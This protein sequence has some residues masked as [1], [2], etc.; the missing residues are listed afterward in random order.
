MAI[1]RK[2]S[3][4]DSITN[5]KIHILE[6]GHAFL[7]TEW[8]LNLT[9]SLFNRLYFVI[10]GEGYVSNAYN[11]ITLEK[12]YVYFLPINN[13]YKLRCD[14]KLEKVYTHF[15]VQI[16]PGIDLFDGIKECSRIKIEKNELDRLVYLLNSDS[17]SDILEYKS[18][19][20]HYVS[21]FLAPYNDKLKEHIKLFSPYASILSYI[22]KNCHAGLKISEIAQHFDI[23]YFSLIKNFKRDMNL[24]LKKYIDENIIRLSQQ[25]LL[26]TDMSIKEIAYSLKFSD[27]FNFSHFFKKHAGM[28]P[29]D[30]RKKNRTTF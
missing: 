4:L 18:I 8:H 12:E 25:K 14:N 20:S 2:N 24:S 16:L 21:R 27:E 9:Y 23:S 10:S 1:L 3:N 30:F 13:P 15:Q 26:L 19:I 7:G 29:R 11:D 6:H 5:L 28:S 17:I 22:E